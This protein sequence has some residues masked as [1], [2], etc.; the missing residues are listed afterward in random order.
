MAY[1]A[2]TGHTSKKTM[3]EYIQN[4]APPAN[5]NTT[6]EMFIV[7]HR[8]Y[9]HI[10]IDKNDCW[11]FEGLLVNGY[12]RISVDNKKYRSHRLSYAIFHIDEDI[13]NK[14]ILHTCDNPSCINP[15]HLRSGT[16]RENIQDCI[17]KGRFSFNLGN[18][19]R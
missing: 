4:I 15:S 2:W 5:L 16:Q 14:V 6:A 18:L 10:R 7:M 11:N 8:L 19:K 3:I 17:N 13:S 12:G 9:K 1:T